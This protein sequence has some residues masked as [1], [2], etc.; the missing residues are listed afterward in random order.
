MH[1]TQFYSL[2]SCTVLIIYKYKKHILILKVP[3]YLCVINIVH[4]VGEVKLSTLN[5][6]NVWNGQL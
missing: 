4:L 2:I 3:K 5:Q 6:K 1:C